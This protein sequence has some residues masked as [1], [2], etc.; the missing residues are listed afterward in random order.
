[1]ADFK[2]TTISSVNDIP[3]KLWND[4]KCTENTYFTPEF[5]GAYEKSNP[6]VDFNYI[7]VKDHNDD[8]VAFAN[9]Q[10]ITLTIDVILKN[11]KLAKPLKK[12][13][14][15]FLCNSPLKILFC[16]NVFLSGEHG[17]FLKKGLDK[18]VL[19]KTITK[20]I[21]ALSKRT[22]PLHAIFVKDFY[23][24]SLYITD[25][26]L[27]F[28]YTAMPVDP[29]MILKLRPEWQSYDDY[30]QDLKSKYR[31]KVNKADSTSAVL[32]MK[33]FNEADFATYK[34][35][36]QALYENTIANA[37][38]NAQVLDLETYVKLRSLYKK[39]FIVQAYFFENKLVGF[40]SALK[41]NDHLDAHFIGLDYGV[42][43]Q[44]A[45]YPRI[46]NDYVRLGIKHQ[47]KQINFGRTASEIKTT[48]G[49]LPEPL[50]CYIRHKRSW[51][52][53]LISP[54]FKMVNLKDFKQ[55]D[56]SKQ[57]KRLNN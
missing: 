49:A 31:V 19:F 33:D 40:L 45:I 24:D 3:I 1:M 34:D 6:Q 9:L 17:I 27:N 48:I 23:K 37:D 11:I 41:T 22:K 51:V 47:V 32:E 46:L 4:L 7:I 52:N 16:G 8:F 39:D 38:F 57:K 55:H 21:S 10:T 2:A 53:N 36:L 56:V 54:F 5:L 14:R 42:S 50:M 18:Y 15:F 26:L 25:E 12:L 30:K 13:L 44:L 43:K 28:E 20:E 29:N 35:Q